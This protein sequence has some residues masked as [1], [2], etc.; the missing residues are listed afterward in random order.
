MSEDLLIDQCSPTMAGIK[1]G[2]LFSCYADDKKTLNADIR[3]FNARLVPK[4]LRLVPMKFENNRAL[5]YMYRPSKLEND[6]NDP[7]AH[8]ILSGLDYSSSGA[9]SKVAIL[10]KKINT[11][12]SFPHE[13][14]LFLGYPPE[15][16]QG[17]IENR[18][19]HCKCVGCWKVYGNVEE[20]KQRFRQYEKCTQVYYT[21]WRKGYSI[22]RLAVTA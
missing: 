13:I 9:D 19:E 1:T 2:S 4:G 5:I 17:F 22:E 15:D 12:E 3:R 6:L 18:A 14:G 11:S 8:S 10:R 20:A 7:T 16:V 21:Q